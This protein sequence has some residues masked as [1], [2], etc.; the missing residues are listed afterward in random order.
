MEFQYFKYCLRF[1]NRDLYTILCANDFDKLCLTKDKKILVFKSTRSLQAYAKANQIKFVFR[2]CLDSLDL[3]AL[4]RW[5]DRPSVTT[6]RCEEFLN[7]WN[8]FT[9]VQSTLNERNMHH[10]DTRYSKIYQKLFWGCNLPAVTPAGR[11]YEPIWS[12]KEVKQ[13]QEVLSEGMCQLRSLLSIRP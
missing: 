5:L 2:E 12:R 7:A 8:L 10:E 1:E 4:E 9:D 3:D 13:I 6:V 11:S